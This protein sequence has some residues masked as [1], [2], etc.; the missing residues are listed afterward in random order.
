[1]HVKTQRSLRFTGAPYH[2]T[3]RVPLFW[4]ERFGR[5]M[6]TTKGEAELLLCV[7]RVS[8]EA[9]LDLVESLHSSPKGRAWVQ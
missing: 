8:E 5:R 2:R 4:A 9:L 6:E 3:V 1:M 7:R